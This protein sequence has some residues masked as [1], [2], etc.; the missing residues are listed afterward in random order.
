MTEDTHTKIED[1]Y[2]EMIAARSMD[3]EAQVLEVIRDM[4]GR[5]LPIKVSEITSRFA[6]RHAEDYDRRITPHWIG[7]ILRR[8]LRLTTYRGTGGWYEITPGQLPKIK[9]LFEKYGISQEKEA[10]ENPLQKPKE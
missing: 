5:K 6:E 3:V 8:K 1:G 9:W 7:A 4:L 10:A 2:H